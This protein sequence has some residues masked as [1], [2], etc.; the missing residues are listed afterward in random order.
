MHEC[1]IVAAV[2]RPTVSCIA[3]LLL[4]SQQR[5]IETANNRNWNKL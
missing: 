2:L 1:A 5:E 4:A 3:Q